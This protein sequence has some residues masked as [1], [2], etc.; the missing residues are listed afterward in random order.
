MYQKVLL[1]KV[2]LKSCTK[3]VLLMFIVHNNDLMQTYCKLA[4]QDCTILV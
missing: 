3:G 4:T 2:L 1:K